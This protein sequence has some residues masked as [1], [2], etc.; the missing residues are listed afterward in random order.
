MANGSD[1]GTKL[2]FKGLC[3]ALLLS[4]KV[5]QVFFSYIGVGWCSILYIRTFL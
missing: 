3:E 1:N 4:F 5:A 2:T